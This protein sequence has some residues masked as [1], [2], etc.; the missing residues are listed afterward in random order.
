MYLDKGSQEGRKVNETPTSITRQGA[1]LQ[2]KTGSI[3]KERVTDKKNAMRQ[4]QRE[5]VGKDKEKR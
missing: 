2:N 3:L 4:G 5:Q 1:N